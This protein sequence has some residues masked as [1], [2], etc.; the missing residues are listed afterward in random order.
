MKDRLAQ[1]KADARADGW[2]DRI[3]TASDEAALLDGCTWNPKLGQHVVDFFATYLRLGEGQWAGQPFVLLPWQRDDVIMPLFSW[4]R[5]DGTRRFRV[6]YVSCGKKNGKSPLA[7][8]V[9]LYMLVG[10]GE[11][12]AKVA[13][14]ATEINQARIVHSDA[15]RMVEASPELKAVLKINHTTSNIGY[16]AQNAWYR[17]WS[18]DHTH[19]A[20]EGYN[21][22]CVIVDELHVWGHA[23]LD[24]VRYAFISRRQPLR[25]QVTTAGVYDETSV[26]WEEYTL[27]KRVLS[28]VVV[29]PERFVYIAEAD[30]GDDWKIEATWHKANP[31]LGSILSAEEIAKACQDAQDTPR[32]E[33][34]F[35]RYRLNQWT[36][37]ATRWLNMDAW[38]ECGGAPEIPDGATVAC[39]A[40]LSSKLDM[41]ALAIV[42]RDPDEVYHAKVYCWLPESCLT[43]TKNNPN[44]KLYQLWH[45]NGY[46]EVT[47]GNVIDYN[48]LRKRVL[49]L[50]EQYDMPE[51]G[52]DPYNAMHV[53]HVLADDGIE[54]FS[55]RQGWQSMNDPSKEVERLIVSRKLRHGGHPILAWAA[56]NAAVEPNKAGN[57]SP[58]KP[59]KSSPLKID[60]LVAMIM[61]IGRAMVMDGGSIYDSEERKDGLLMV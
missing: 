50:A 56:Q 35:R 4:V 57:I 45:K 24:A 39:C 47:P 31:S 7:A 55:H 46:L 38:N 13:S 6:A 37:Q 53:M 52:F 19:K 32:L 15:I 51:I 10:D 11:P 12:G 36:A 28:G 5:A 21:L 20:K 1:L 17:A 59:Q 42:Y 14:A 3:V 34:D 33:N 9:G 2:A 44:Q 61:A 23:L 22:H 18:G 58:V 30:K 60:A 49:E 54:V 26:G 40:D 48:L 41:T 43:E 16:L 8:G 29:D 27:S 25:F